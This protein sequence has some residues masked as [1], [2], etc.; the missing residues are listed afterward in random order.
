MQLVKKSLRCNR[1]RQLRAAN[2][3]DT[4]YT[5]TN[6]QQVAVCSDIKADYLGQ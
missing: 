6:G 1:N 4:A 3:S 2:K 5:I